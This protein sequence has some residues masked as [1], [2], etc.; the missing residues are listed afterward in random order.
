MNLFTNR[1]LKLGLGLNSP[2]RQ[3]NLKSITPCRTLTVVPL[4]LEMPT[5]VSCL[6]LI[7]VPL[8]LIG[9]LC[10]A[11]LLNLESGALVTIPEKY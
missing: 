5:S 6:Q 2:F 11:S 1:S 4:L 8:L 10:I 7:S 9:V 3:Y